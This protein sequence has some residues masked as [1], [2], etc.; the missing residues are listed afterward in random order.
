M[1]YKELLTQAM[2][3]MA[4]DKRFMCVG[5]NTRYGGAGA[6]TFLGVTEE[7]RIEMPLAE[8]VMTFA[9]IGMSLDGLLPLIWFERADFTYIALDA[10]KNQLD[11]LAELSEGLHRPACIIR[12]CVGNSQTPLFTGIT[13]TFNPADAYRKLFRNIEVMELIHKGAIEWSYNYAFDR[14]KSGKSTMLFEF[15]D[16]YGM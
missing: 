15:K 3:D 16:F 14:L 10:L 6:G 11:V 4:E 2:T 1:T 9:A 12:I 8:S 7:Q 5:Y 13:H